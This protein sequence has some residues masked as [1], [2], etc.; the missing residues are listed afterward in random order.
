[1]RSGFLN[2]I[3]DR[4]YLYQCTNLEGLDKLMS[5]STVVA[6][7]GFDCTA[8]SLHIGSLIQIMMLRHLQQFGHK[9]IILLGGGTTKIGDPTGKDKAR[10]ILDK[11]TISSNISRIK[12]TLEK[13]ISLEGAILV[14]NADWLNSL[15]YIDFLRDVGIHFSINRMLNFESVK[16]RL[17][18][19]QSLSFLE[20]NYMLLQAYDFVELSRNY[21]CRLQIG[22]SDQ[23]GNI[24]NGIELGNKLNMPELFGLTTPLITTTAGK[25]MGKT[26]EGKTIWLDSEMCSPYDYWQYFRNIED[27]NLGYFLRLFTELSL[28]K[29]KKLESLIGQEI[30]EAKKALATGATKICHGE[31]AAKDAERAAV[32]NFENKD[33]SLLP[34]VYIEK[35]KIG[36]VGISAVELLHITDLVDSKGAAKRFIEGGGCRINDK[37]ISN[38]NQLVTLKDFDASGFIKLSVG[39]KRHIRVILLF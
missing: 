18:R 5:S 38:L 11:N 32:A 15:K 3:K 25:K 21:G 22:G 23:W 31:D 26:A 9:A 36:D 29:I 34:S 35:Q 30:N 37:I 14:N 6:Y 17:E 27:N 1:M 4:G 12:K 28:D 10:E 13:F 19:E 7:I 20:F 8:P 16:T 2:F 24:V 33:S 39:K